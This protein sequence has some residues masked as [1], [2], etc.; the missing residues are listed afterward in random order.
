MTYNDI[1][2]HDGWVG[3]FAVVE[4]YCLEFDLQTV[5]ITSNIMQYD[6][7]L[8]VVIHYSNALGTLSPR[9]YFM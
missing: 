6:I 5:F 7:W 3:G 2:K 8:S 1:L 9:F 4:V